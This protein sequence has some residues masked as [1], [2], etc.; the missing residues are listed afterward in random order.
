M[1][2]REKYQELMEAQVEYQ[3]KIDALSDVLCELDSTCLI[4]CEIED[5]FVQAVETALGDED[6]WTSY[7]L[8][9]RGGDLSKPCVT[10]DDGT[11]QIDTS[12]WGKVYDLIMRGYD[13]SE[14]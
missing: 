8:Y 5:L 3:K 12:D 4:S 2:T 7:F 1:I 11:T 13:K 6:G 10:K 9:E 14:G